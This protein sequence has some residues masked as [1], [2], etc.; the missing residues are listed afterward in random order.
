MKQG[1]CLFGY[2]NERAKLI[3]CDQ[4]YY[5]YYYN[6]YYYNYYFYYLLI[7]LFVQQ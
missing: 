6:Y 2:Q 5:Y 1:I 4:C 7:F 3:S